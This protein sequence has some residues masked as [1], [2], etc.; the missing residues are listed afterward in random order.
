MVF[1]FSVIRRHVIDSVANPLQ[2]ETKWECTKCELSPCHQKWQR[3]YC[4]IPEETDCSGISHGKVLSRVERKTRTKKTSHQSLDVEVEVRSMGCE[5]K[6]CKSSAATPQATL[7]AISK[8]I[9]PQAMPRAIFEKNFAFRLC[10]GANLKKYLPSGY[11]SGYASGN[12]FAMPR[13]IFEKNFAFRLCLGANLKKYLP[14]G[15]ASGYA[16]G[17]IFIAQGNA[18]SCPSGYAL[19]HPRG[20]LSLNN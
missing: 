8:N 14:S 13:A 2:G 1:I 5:E 10:L 17:N 7:Q 12:I 15:Y 16:S 19:G 11:A 9:N 20:C 4:N 18:L 6:C 3:R